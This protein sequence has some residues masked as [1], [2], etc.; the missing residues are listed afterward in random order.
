M[1]L[2]G[3]SYKTKDWELQ[4]IEFERVN[5]VVGKNSTGKTRTLGVL[6]LLYEIISQKR[7]IFEPA[8]WRVSFL[9]G[10]TLIE[11]EFEIGIN[12]NIAYVIKEELYEDG[13]I[14]FER[15]TE[16]VKIKN[17]L[18]NNSDLGNPPSNKL[19]IHAF[20]DLKKYPYIEEIVKWAE[21]SFGFRFGNLHAKYWLSNKDYG[22]LS[23]T[24]QIPMLLDSLSDSSR[25]KIIS[26]LNAIG[27]LVEKLGVLVSSG[28]YIIILNEQYLDKSLLQDNISQGMFR[29]LAALIF[30]EYLI[31]KRSTSIIAIDDFCEGLDYERATKL[32]KLLFDKCLSNNIQLIATSNDM[33][34]MDVVGLEYW[35]VLQRHGHTVTAISA[36]NHPQLFEDFKFTGLSNFDF[37]AS[38]YIAQNLEK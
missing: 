8:E 18:S 34:L 21:Q 5:L 6:H 3:L 20:R 12:N 11:Y 36:K 4:H 10:T 31:S 13:K 29:S 23:G 35:N 16:T 25:K 27:F 33:F 17:L 26:E 1:I 15:A 14:L 28:I 19:V 22:I 9:N 2:K 38:D 32:G 37:F 24:D 30:A 7:E